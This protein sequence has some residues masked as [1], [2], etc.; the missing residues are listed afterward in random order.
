MVEIGRVW[1]VGS[2]TA[3]HRRHDM[4]D[5][6]WERL[7]PH[8]PG[9]EGKRGWP[10]TTGGLSTPCAG[11]CAPALPRIK[12]GAGSGGICPRTTETGRTPI[13]PP[14]KPGG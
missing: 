1:K 4:T 2:M 9:G 5:D 7:R 14:V 8:L 10:M 3:A 13:G 6:V 11:F 12:Y